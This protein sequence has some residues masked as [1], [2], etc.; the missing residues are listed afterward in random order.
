MEFFTCPC[1]GTGNVIL[2][3]K[4]MGPNRND[5]GKLLTKQCNAGLHT[6]RL[7][8]CDGRSCDPASVKVQIKDTDP[9]FPTEV[10]FKCV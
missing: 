7:Q 5:S 2:D 6:V 4:E 9:I 8:C 1:N 3:G 10:P